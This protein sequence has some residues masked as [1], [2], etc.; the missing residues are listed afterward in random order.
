MYRISHIGLDC[1][2]LLK[3]KSSGLNGGIFYGGWSRLIR[4]LIT[5]QKTGNIQLGFPFPQRQS[6]YDYEP[7]TM[8]LIS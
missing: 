4:Y 7:I 8:P 5:C 6:R 3:G 2:N 1:V